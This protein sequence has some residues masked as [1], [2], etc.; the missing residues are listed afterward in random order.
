MNISV[1]APALGEALEETQKIRRPQRRGGQADGRLLRRQAHSG[2][3]ARRVRGRRRH[4]L[5]GGIYPCALSFAGGRAA[6]KAA[7][8]PRLGHSHTR[9][10]G[11]LPRQI[12]AVRQALRRRGG[13]RGVR[14]HSPFILLGHLRGGDLGPR[15]RAGCFPD[16]LHD[17]AV[18]YSEYGLLPLKRAACST[19][20]SICGCCPR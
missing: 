13:G 8:Q 10:Y 7:F 12:A 6:G 18:I 14:H 11:A 3:G 19:G 15:A 2:G 17:I 9:N 1:I 20:T 4:L 5:R 16:K